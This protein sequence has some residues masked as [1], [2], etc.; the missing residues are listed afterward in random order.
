V[1]EHATPVEGKQ[2]QAERN[3]HRAKEH[4][5]FGVGRGLTA[6]WLDTTAAGA[7]FIVASRNCALSAHRSV[8]GQWLQRSPGSFAKSRPAGSAVSRPRWRCAVL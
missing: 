5:Q 1:R 7:G 3:N 6:F 4:P 2:D 8:G